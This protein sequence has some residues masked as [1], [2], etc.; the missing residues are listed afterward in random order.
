[1]KHS[2]QRIHSSAKGVAA[3][4]VIILIL[5]IVSYFMLSESV[6][7][8]Q[9]LKVIIRFFVTGLLVIL[10]ILQ[11]QQSKGGPL[12]T[13]T[14]PLPVLFYLGYLFLGLCSLLW[15]SSFSDSTL[16]LM[17]DVEGLVFAFLFIKAWMTNN[18]S[19]GLRFS[20]LLA[21]SI[22]IIVAVFLLGMIINPELFYRMT[23]GGEEARLGGFIINPNELGLLIGV[24]IG[25]TITDWKFATR[26]IFYALA[27][28]M[29][30]YAL[31]LTGSR[32]S[33]IALMLIVFFFIMQTK[34]LRIRIVVIL[35]VLAAIPFVIKSVIIKQGNIDEVMNM[36]GRIPFWKDL[37]S[38]NFPREPIFGYGYM[39][40]DYTD[41]FESINA[42]AGAMTHNTFLQAL[43]GLGLVGLTIVL[44]QLAL[45]VYTIF[46]TNHSYK[47]RLAIAILIP[48]LINS[49][50]EFGIFGET[51]YGI[52]FYL[53]IV[54]MI[55]MEPSK[56]KL[57]TRVSATFHARTPRLPERSSAS[58]PIIL[59]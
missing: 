44:A 11:H 58:A 1:M 31:V 8:T 48:L 56:Q 55:C 9:A 22:G 45:T 12:L 42:Y 47:R 17:M 14:N 2:T 5:R 43:M 7:I 35:S 23:H 40:I 29:F 51:N 34:D 52:L 30:I 53:M 39:R 18:A 49:F 33:M 21:V 3:L 27:I 25:A 13:F 20:K 50:T 26:K 4:L 54:F 24:G 32:S 46:K 15:T 38:I 37:L 41:K 19:S 6:F 28:L 16:Q 36:T 57:R 10:L 59:Q